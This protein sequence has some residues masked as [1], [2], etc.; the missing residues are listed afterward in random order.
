MC[1]PERYKLTLTNG[2]Q[3]GGFGSSHAAYYLDASR[4]VHLRGSARAG[5]AGKAVF[6]APGLG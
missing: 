3:Y 5:M 4:I 1:Q 6:H 2:W